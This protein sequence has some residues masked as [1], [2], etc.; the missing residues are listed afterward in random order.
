MSWPASA[1]DDQ[2]IEDMLPSGKFD[3][4]ESEETIAMVKASKS[5]IL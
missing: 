4:D 1:K 3:Q 2:D 5:T